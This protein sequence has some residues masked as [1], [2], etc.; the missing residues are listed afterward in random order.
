MRYIKYTTKNEKGAF[1]TERIDAPDTEID[2]LINQVSAQSRPGQ[3]R[4]KGRLL[5][6]RNIEILDQ[7]EDTGGH[8]WQEKI[9]EWNEWWQTNVKRSPEEKTEGNMSY[10][11]IVHFA[12][13]GQQPTAEERA[14]AKEKILT[15]FQENTHRNRFD[16]SL[17]KGLRINEPQQDKEFAT[18]RTLLRSAAVSVMERAVEADIKQSRYYFK[19]HYEP[20]PEPPEEVKEEIPF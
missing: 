6:S 1:E 7:K 14:A 4:F 3:I 8:E 5:I 11:D 10:Y 15:F 9:N 2:W 19:E 12:H 17:F 18:P 13:T 16:Y 20:L